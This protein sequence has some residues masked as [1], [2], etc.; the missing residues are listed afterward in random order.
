[1]SPEQARGQ[2]VDKRTDIWAFGC[3]LYEMLTGRAVR[4]R[5]VSDTIAAVSSA[6]R[7]GAALP[8]S[9]PATSGGCC[10]DCLEKDP[11]RRL[12]DIGDAGLEIEAA[13]VEGNA[14]RA[15]SVHLRLAI[16]PTAEG[17]AVAAA[18]LLAVGVADRWR[19]VRERPAARTIVQ[20]WHRASILRLTSDSG[21]T[22]EPTISAERQVDCVC[23]RIAAATAT[24]T[25]GFSRRREGLRDSAHQRSRR[26]PRARRIARWQPHRLSIRPNTSRNLRGAWALGGDARLIA[27]DGMAPRFSPD[28][29][30]IAFWTGRWF[31]SS[32][33]RTGGAGRTY[34]VPTNRRRRS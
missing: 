27:P 9:T 19:A 25:S 3:V 1:M 23:T 4:R 10:S 30:L 2:P 33:H 31:G 20:P 26:R 12:R 6:S 8:P 11:K 24:W 17:R 14:R 16:A 29:R 21:L 28:G 22:M 13:L 34:V 15:A 18:G 5:H 7:T 32:K